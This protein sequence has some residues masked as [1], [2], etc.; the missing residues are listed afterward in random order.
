MNKKKILS[1]VTLLTIATVSTIGA[2]NVYATEGHI[3]NTEKNVYIRFDKEEYNLTSEKLKELLSEKG[4]TLITELTGNV[5]TGTKIAVEKDGINYDYIVVLLGDVNKDGEMKSSDV[6]F[7]RDYVF[8]PT[9]LE[10]TPEQNEAADVDGDGKIGSTDIS[11]LRDMLMGEYVALIPDEE[12]PDSLK[13]SAEQALA[14]LVEYVDTDITAEN[15]E[16]ITTAVASAKEAVA[17]LDGEIVESLEG[18]ENIATIE[19]K[20]DEYNKSIE[21]NPEE[22][23]LAK[24]KAEAIK[25]LSEKYPQ[26]NYDVE[27]WKTVEEA[28]A[29][30]ENKLNTEEAIKNCIDETIAVMSTKQTKQQ[31]LDDAIIKA[32]TELEELQV[33]YKSTDYEEK[34]LNDIKAII[35]TATETLDNL[36]KTTATIADINNIVDNAENE[37]KLVKTKLDLAKEEAKAYLDNYI[38]TD[39]KEE[40]YSTENWKKIKELVQDGIDSID[41]ISAG[42]N[43]DNAIENVKHIKEDIIIEISA[44]KNKATDL[45]NLKADKKLE[46]DNIINTESDTNTYTDEQKIEINKLKDDAKA[47]IDLATS[48]EEVNEIANTVKSELSKYR[49][50]VQ[51]QAINS[52]NETY[53][54]EDFYSE[55]WANMIKIINKAISDIENSSDAGVSS[56]VTDLESDLSSYISIADQLIAAKS[57]DIAALQSKYVENN[58]DAETW[59]ELKTE[60]DKQVELINQKITKTQVQIAYDNAVSILDTFE[61]KEQKLNKAKET[62]KKELDEE[63]T[64]YNQ[65]DYSEANWKQLQYLVSI[66]QTKIDEKTAEADINNSKTYIIKEMKKVK[67]IAQEALDESKTDAIDEITTEYAKYSSII[68]DTTVYTQENIDI[69]N[70]LNTNASTEINALETIEEVNAKKIEIINAMKA[71]KKTAQSDLETAISKTYKEEDYYSDD[72]KKI[73]ELVNNAIT[74]IKESYDATEIATEKTNAINAIN[75]IDTKAEVLD[76]AKATAKDEIVAK[77]GNL[78][79]NNPEIWSE[80]SQMIDTA[81]AKIDDAITPTRVDQIKNEEIEAIDAYITS[82]NTEE[83]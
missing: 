50:D 8:D 19:A 39:I 6:T 7:L 82:L 81:K 28:I 44:I 37:A 48:E 10:I 65:E 59:T 35:K 83:E 3:K 11:L 2:R 22:I 55:D 29:T 69:I 79:T 72:W 52:I 46:I 27:D 80:I 34:E 56:I 13:D 9:A 31:K 64:K 74:K 30:I 32:K 16:E 36:D 5:G 54:K 61:T 66:G 21:E 33:A 75:D 14:K 23:A 17:K 12:L 20:I 25:T 45:E 26:E 60:Y 77:Y 41:E 53:K 68:T 76:T 49:T 24:A 58:Y 42:V 62:A 70:S 1:A 47:Q 67:T 43:M 18:Y 63:L 4:F 38:L 71:V 15:I 73:N 40:N 57:D 78:E 51:N